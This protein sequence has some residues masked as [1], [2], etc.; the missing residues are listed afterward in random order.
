M[1]KKTSKGKKLF[2]TLSF[3]L[4]LSFSLISLSPKLRSSPTLVQSAITTLI[5]PFQT[6]FNSIIQGTSDSFDHYVFLS[7]VSQEN[8]ELK[9]EIENL[10]HRENRLREDIFR[11]QREHNIL[12]HPLKT[13]RKSII[14]SVIGKDSGQWLK[15]IVIDK[16][17]NQ[18]LVEN[19][20]VVTNLGILGQV[21]EA[22]PKSSK[23]LL[24]S[25]SRSAVDAIFQKSREPGVVF[26]SG[27]QI[28]EMRYVSMEA[29]IQKGDQII[30]SGVGG[31]FPKGLA[32]GTVSK[33]IKKKQGLFQEIQVMPSVDFSRLEEML[34]LIPN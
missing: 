33:I 31:I 7:N 13:P 16:G 32:V 9:K 11:L 10:T 8:E 18:G 6:F 34:V 30:S 2:I 27:E 14:A 4:I 12:Q 25:D 1:Q 3:I 26:G 20:A 5:F 17:S 28:C 19:S 15:T 23:I 22:N 24:I 29:D 21:I